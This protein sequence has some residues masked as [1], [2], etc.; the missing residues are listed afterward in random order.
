MELY[1]RF[2]LN[3]KGNGVFHLSGRGDSLSDD[4][5]T[6]I[7]VLKEEECDWTLVS[8]STWVSPSSNNTHLI[9]VF[10]PRQ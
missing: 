2:G 3:Y 5:S 1:A 10:E 7:M 6:I 9:A 8:T 4:L